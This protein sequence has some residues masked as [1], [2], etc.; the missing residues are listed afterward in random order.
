MGI[1]QI[2][3]ISLAYGERELLKEVS[4]TIAETSRFALTGPNGCGKT[5][6]LKIISK[7][8]EPD[9]GSILKSNNTTVSYLP[10]A[11]IVHKELT[12]YKEVEK[13][14]D[15]YLPL[16]KR[17]ESLEKSLQKLG[18]QENSAGLL[19]E[20]DEIQENLLSSD[21]YNRSS[22]ISHVLKGL[23]FSKQDESR[24]C[25]L[26]SG[27]WQM[28][29][30]LAKILLENSS[31]LL[32]DEPTNYLDIESRIWLRNYLKGIK[33]SV[34]IVSHDQDFLDET[35]DEVY[36]LFNGKLRRYKGNY[37]TYEKQRKEELAVLVQQYKEQQKEFEKTTQFIERF[38]YKASKAKQVQSRI[39]QLD[40]TEVIEI[41]GHL[42]TLSFSFP[43]PPHSPNDVLT[44]ESLSKSYGLIKLFND[45]SFK[46]NKGDRLAV[47]GRNGSGKTTLLKLLANGRGADNGSINYGPNVK[48]GYFAQE[49]KPTFNP[50][51]TVLEEIQQSAFTSDIPRLRGLLGSFLF[52]G[53]D[54]DKKVSVLSGGELSRLALLKI[55]L[56]PL[57]LLILDEPTNHLDINSKQVLLEA[58]KKYKGTVIFV[59]HDKHF[60]KNLATRILYLGD[61]EPQFFEGDYSYF[62]WKLEQQEA[63]EEITEVKEK[64]RPETHSSYKEANRIRNQ[65]QKYQ[66]EAEE[67]LLSIEKAH[68]EIDKIESLMGLEENYS[69]G[70]KIK[71]LIAN[72]N[73]VEKAIREDEQRWFLIQEELHQLTQTLN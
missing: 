52:S 60:L 7:I 1:C 71:N 47:S 23:G 24:Q 70:S 10:Q 62:A 2:E 34:I 73:S 64:E 39:K 41:P 4:F 21:Y 18:E 69:D 53:D 38:R 42:R 31:I 67:L 46:V 44:V 9:S 6:L 56:K 35:V 66:K 54:I 28:R 40:K 8:I 17:K 45:F 33:N 11:D 29:I 37:S 63:L 25:A 61:K 50:N 3:N 59:S 57:N 49:I 51:N 55:L 58:L 14:F 32:L 68:Q 30:A 27:G 20:L 72:K 19:I 16:L 12:L 36:E 65:I 22:K 43:S 48:V 15:Y 26:F 5:T 13:A